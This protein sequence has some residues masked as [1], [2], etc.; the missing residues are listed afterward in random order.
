MPCGSTSCRSMFFSTNVPGG[1]YPNV[2]G[3]SVE[4]H[5]SAISVNSYSRDRL[6][7]RKAWNTTPYVNDIKPR[8]G[9]FRVV[10]NAGDTLSRVN[11]SCGGP[12]MISSTNHS[13]MFLSNNKDGGQSSNNCDDSGIPPSTCNV[14]YVYDSSDYIRFKK[15]QVTNRGYAGLGTDLGEYSSGGG[16]N[17]AQVAQRRPVRI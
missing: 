16:N 8:I 1:T 10:N 9:T 12:N 13:R 2:K 14:K 3:A 11:Y 7:L 4:R 17:G 5:N 6:H 15:L